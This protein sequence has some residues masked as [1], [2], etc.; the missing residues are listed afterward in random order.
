MLCCVGMSKEFRLKCTPCRVTYQ[1]IRYA[2]DR[3][4]TVRPT[5]LIEEPV[6]DGSAQP[7]GETVRTRIYDAPVDDPTTA[8]LIR[9]EAASQRRNRNAK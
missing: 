3:A 9:R 5:R 6:T 1:G 8:N 4:G 7:T 2:I